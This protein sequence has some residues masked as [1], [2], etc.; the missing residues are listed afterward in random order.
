VTA[1]FDRDLEF[2]ETLERRRSQSDTITWTVPGLA[3]AAEAFL[4]TVALRPETEPAARLVS[5]MAGF[6]IVF[7][8]LRL[9]WKSVFNFDLWDATINEQRRKMHYMEFVHAMTCSIAQRPFQPKSKSGKGS[10]Q[11]AGYGDG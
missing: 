2:L 1:P 10:T 4:L 7:A 3:V 8:A 11:S 6:I 5:A 9:L